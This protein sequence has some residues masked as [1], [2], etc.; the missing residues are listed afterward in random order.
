VKKR[1]TRMLGNEAEWPESLGFVYDAPLLSAD[2]NTGEETLLMD[3]A[4]FVEDN[5]QLRLITQR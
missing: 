5:H 3:L 2:K 4:A 1:L